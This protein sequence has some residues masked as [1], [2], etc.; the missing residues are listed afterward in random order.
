MALAGYPPPV[1]FLGDL[2]LQAEITTETTARVRTAVHPFIVGPGGGVSIGVLATVV[3]VVGG[4]IAAR[5]LH[6]DWMATADLVVDVVGQCAGPAVEARGRVVRRG[7]TTLV[8]EAEVVAVEEDGRD[9]LVG[10]E[11]VGPVAWAS[12]TFAVLPAR[13]PMVGVRALGAV[14]IRWSF[15]G[16]GLASPVAEALG[17]VLEDGPTGR[18]SLPVRPYLLNS[19]GAVQGGVVAVVAEVAA[20]AAL[21]TTLGGDGAD[22]DVTDL[23]IAYLAQGKAGPVVS[24]TRVLGPGPGGRLGAVVELHDAGA[25]QRLLAVVHVGAVPIAEV[26]GAEVAGGSPARVAP[27]AR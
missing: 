8:I 5:V 13:E 27:G 2:C 1:H 14:P 18:V 16:D 21:G 7:R 24:S 26:A 11:P 15:E 19:F 22:V 3:D 17:L 4:S 10:G 6:P 23:Q 25:D 12:M 9:V 20:A